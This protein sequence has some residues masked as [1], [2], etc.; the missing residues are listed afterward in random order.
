[1]PKQVIRI[2]EMPKTKSGKTLRRLLK[3]LYLN[4]CKKINFDLSTISNIEII[5]QLKKEI[6]FQK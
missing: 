5:T 2:N 3:I 1:M 4:P 6:K